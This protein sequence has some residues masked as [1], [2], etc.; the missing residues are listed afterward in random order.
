MCGSV[1]ATP[2]LRFQINVRICGSDCTLAQRRGSG[3]RDGTGGVC[4]HF[5]HSLCV[6]RMNELD[7]CFSRSGAGSGSGSGLGALQAAEEAALAAQ[8][9]T[10]PLIPK[11]SMYALSFLLLAKLALNEC[12]FGCEQRADQS[13]FRASQRVWF[14]TTSVHLSC[15]VA[16]SKPL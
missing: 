2:C 15:F 10:S 14:L 9:T 11:R 5:A 6:G 12:M 4:M 3:I 13:L 7:E 8:Q 1:D 16:S